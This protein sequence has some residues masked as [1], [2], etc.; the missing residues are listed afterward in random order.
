MAWNMPMPTVKQAGIGDLTAG[1]AAG[2][3]FGTGI[4][5]GMIKNEEYKKA[6]Q[7]NIEALKQRQALQAYIQSGGGQE[8][9]DVASEISPTTG[10]GLQ[11]REVKKIANAVELHDRIKGATY[12]DLK[13]YKEQYRPQMI[14][15]GLP[16]AMLP[17]VNTTEELNQLLFRNE[18]M[19]AQFKQKTMTPDKRYKQVAPG[20]V[21]DTTN[22]KFI[23]DT[24]MVTKV[25]TSLARPYAEGGTQF[26]TA[27]ISAD[28]QSRERIKGMEYTG[29]KDFKADYKKRNPDASEEDMVKA[30]SMAERSGH[31]VQKGAKQAGARDDFMSDSE[32]GGASNQPME[33]LPD[34]GKNK[35][36]TVRDT[37]TGKRL[38]SDGK[39]WKPVD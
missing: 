1:L 29:W 28:Q 24:Q 26:D 20:V 3:Q 38:K 39:D 23:R 32:T 16:P 27:P 15:L 7:A 6:Q 37:T 11:D 9:I 10:M 17:D 8:G 35:G 34:A 12:G 36:R 33:T 18:Q 2:Q 14:K 19:A 13:N 21:L 30:Y 5:E 22:G 25:G 31:I 4:I